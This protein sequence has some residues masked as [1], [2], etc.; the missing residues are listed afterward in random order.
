MPSYIA[1]IPPDKPLRQKPRTAILQFI[2]RMAIFL[3]L[4]R[5]C[6]DKLYDCNNSMALTMFKVP[7]ATFVALFS[8]MTGPLFA[9]SQ[10][11][12]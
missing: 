3:D 10:P 2:R 1:P 11:L 7:T 9:Q 5:S 8:L 4:M 12:I 6:S